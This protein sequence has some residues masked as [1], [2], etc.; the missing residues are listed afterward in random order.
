MINPFKFQQGY[1]LIDGIQ[2]IQQI[3][4]ADQPAH[5]KSAGV[6]IKRFKM[7]HHVAGFVHGFDTSG[8]NSDAQLDSS[9]GQKNAYCGGRHSMA[10]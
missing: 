4:G 8:V 3:V 6:F 10:A 1:T 2:N 9:T 7:K 5:F